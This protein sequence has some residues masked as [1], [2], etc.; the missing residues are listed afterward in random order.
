VHNR[1]SVRY[2]WNG[3]RNAAKFIEPSMSEGYEAFMQK[4]ADLF[5]D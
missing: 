2:F 1:V 5:I 4:F 3:G